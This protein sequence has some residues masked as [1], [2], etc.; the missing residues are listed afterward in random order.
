MPSEDPD[1]CVWG[2]AYKI[3]AH[4]VQRVRS[5]L[6]HREKGGYEAR[7]VVFNP[8]PSHPQFDTIQLTVYIGTRDNP[9]FLGPASN[10]EMARQIYHSVGPSGPNKDYLLNL[11]QAVRSIAPHANDPHLF[12]LEEEVIAMDCQCQCVTSTDE[13]V[14]GVSQTKAEHS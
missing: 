4:D 10:Q 3:S 12:S 11:A 6:D 5:H 7:E 14:A 8:D 13:C 9:F 2:V 1:E